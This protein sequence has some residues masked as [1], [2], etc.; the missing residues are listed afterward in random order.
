[1]K[2]TRTSCFLVLF[3]S[4]FATAQLSFGAGSLSEELESAVGSAFERQS[5]IWFSQPRLAHSNIG[6]DKARLLYVADNEV[7]Y[8]NSE[9]L[10]LLMICNRQFILGGKWYCSIPKYRSHDGQEALDE[11]KALVDKE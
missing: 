10:L 8:I 1:M 4:A 3:T 6:S 2:R 9:F 7:P 5:S 11:F